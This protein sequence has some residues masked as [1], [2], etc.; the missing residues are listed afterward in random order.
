MLLFRLA[1]VPKETVAE[2]Y[3]LTDLGLWEEAPRLVGNLLK[4][5]N[6]GLDEE[7][8][9]QILVAKKEYVLGLCDVLEETL[10]RG[11]ALFQE[12]LEDERGGSAGYQECLG[13]GRTTDFWEQGAKGGDRE[14]YLIIVHL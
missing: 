10:W 1:G 6:L 7:T 13:G 3:A 2:E 4:S 8:V 9:K 5:P 11:G 12:R 14:W